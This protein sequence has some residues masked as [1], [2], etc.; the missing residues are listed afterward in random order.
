MKDRAMQA[1]YLMALDLWQKLRE[2]YTPM[3]SVNI[4]AVKMQ[5]R[6]AIFFYAR[7]TNHLNGF[8]RETSK[9]ALTI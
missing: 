8:W 1:L 6:N 5:S 2:I 7:M 4:G 9:V 3:V